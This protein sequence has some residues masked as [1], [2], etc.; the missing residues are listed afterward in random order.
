MSE[1]WNKKEREKRKQKERQDKAEKMQQRREKA[2]EGKNPDSMIAY[3]NENGNFSTTPPDPRKKIIIEL[4]DIA[5]GVPR[6][7][8]LPQE[9]L[10]RNGNVTFFNMSKGFRFIKDNLSQQ[11]IF[12]HANNL[13]GAIQENDKVSFEVEMSHRGL[14][15]VNV[16]IIS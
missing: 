8:D 14:M 7:E 13:S 6:Q 10:I 3:V 15:A 12:V 11:S 16:K 4:E 1:S 9:E 2:R 5:I